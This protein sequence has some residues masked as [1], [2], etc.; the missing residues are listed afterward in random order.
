M[1]FTPARHTGWWSG[2]VEP[3]DPAVTAEDGS[4]TFAVT[5][6]MVLAQH[7]RRG[8]AH[9]MHDILLAHRREQ[10]ATLLVE[11]DNAPARSAY[12][13][14]GWQVLG[15]LQPFADSP[16]RWCQPTRRQRPW[17]SATVGPGR[18]AARG[19]RG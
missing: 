1:G 8:Y 14:W 10:R 13:S 7:H 9:L 6:I 16:R 3:V 15:D 2:L 12:L 19:R 11:P 17:W 5:E 18:Q 4:R